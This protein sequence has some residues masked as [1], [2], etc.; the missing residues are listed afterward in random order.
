LPSSI[1]LNYRLPA[2]IKKG[3]ERVS[4]DGAV[5]TASNMLKESISLRADDTIRGT[6]IDEQGK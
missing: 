6:F 1:R 4:E 5:S 3:M 2:I